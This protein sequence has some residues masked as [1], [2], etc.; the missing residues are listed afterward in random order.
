MSAKIKK[1]VL[2]DAEKCVKFLC[3]MPLSPSDCLILIDQ[4]C[5]MTFHTDVNE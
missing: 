1:R 3:E 5:I 2:I 4:T